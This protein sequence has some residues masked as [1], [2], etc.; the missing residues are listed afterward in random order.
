MQPLTL[1]RRL[2]SLIPPAGMNLIRYNGILASAAKYRS[3]VVPAPKLAL[4]VSPNGA[5]PARP[6]RRD[7]LDWASLLR[8]VYQ[9]DIRACP[10][11]GRIRVIAAIE[12]PR[13]IRR[14]LDHLGMPTGPPVVA[15][16][17]GPPDLFD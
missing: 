2:A 3:R 6:N 15:A 1:V 17:R 13:V 14:I 9:I 7:G 11:G 12:K 8:R 4:A 10:C 16:A 5:A